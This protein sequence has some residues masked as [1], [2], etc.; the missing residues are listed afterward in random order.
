[1]KTQA[2]GPMESDADKK[3]AGH[4]L[5]L[6]FSE[7][8]ARLKA[9]WQD[10][11]IASIC[12][13]MPSV[14]ILGANVAAALDKTQLSHADMGFLKKIAEATCNGYCAGCT[15]VC[16]TAMPH[17][18]YISDVMRYLMYYNNYGIKE[19]ARELFEKIPAGV[20]TT[21]NRMDYRAAELNCPHRLPIGKLMADAAKLFA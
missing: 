9:V 5:Q 8:Q 21:F 10:N 20:R 12:S 11:R 1:M 15:D 17:M 7:H 14:S 2:M 6:G 3:L 13:Q 16:A 19:K 4:F 18:P